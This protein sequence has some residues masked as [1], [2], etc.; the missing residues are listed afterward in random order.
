MENNNEDVQNTKKSKP[1]SEKKEWFN[2]VYL[3]YENTN[4][5]QPNYTSS[6]KGFNCFKFSSFENAENA[7]NADNNCN[8]N[9][10]N[11]KHQDN[12]RHT[13]I[14]ICK[15]VPKIFDKYILNLELRNI[16]WNGNINIKSSLS[17]PYCY[18]NKSPKG[19]INK[20]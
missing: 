15:W 19:G 3:C 14:P 18:I 16:Y 13:I 5:L 9:K 11:I 6:I 10:Y 20:K 17:F 2:R 4:G 7:E 1:S 12:I 8:I